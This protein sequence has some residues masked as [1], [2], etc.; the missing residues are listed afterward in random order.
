MDARRGADERAATGPDASSTPTGRGAPRHTRDEILSAAAAW[1]WLPRGSQQHRSHLQLVRHPA[2]LGGGVRAARV[3]STMPA[4]AVLD[5]AV[6][7]TRSWGEAQ[8]TFWTNAA[9]RPDL[10]DELRRRGA[11][12]CDTVAVL[13]APIDELVIPVPDDIAVETVRTLEQVRELDH[14]NVVVWEQQPLPADG[15]REEHDEITSTL[16]RGAGCRVLA[17]LDRSAVGTGGCTIADGF[18]RLWGAATLPHVRGRGAYRGVLAGRLRLAAEHGATT[19]LVKGRI[20]TSAPILRRVGFEHV[21]DER[22]YTLA[23]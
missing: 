14:I 6:Q 15:L 11:Q 23:V 8:L 10:E 2:R 5:H 4:A 3:Q 18:A 7:C 21:G 19:A 17:R 20:S 9:D 12:H 16:A 22:A 1:V 13:A